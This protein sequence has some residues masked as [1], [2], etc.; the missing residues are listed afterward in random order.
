MTQQ[1]TQERVYAVTSVPSSA[2]SPVNE[3][4][5][6]AR[7]L[8]GDVMTRSVV[9]ATADAT[10]KDI[11]AAMASNRISTIPVVDD[12]HHVLGVV[13]A[14]DLLA[15]I[16]GERGRPPRGH[17]LGAGH[18]V[19]VKSHALTAA[20]LMTAPAVTT[21]E[22]M[23]I[24]TAA[25]AAALGKVRCL[26][27]VD[28]N[29]V[30]VGIATK[31]DLVKVFLRDDET[32]R[33]DILERV[34]GEGML[35]EP[36]TIDVAVGG[37]VVSLSGQLERKMLK[38]QLLERVWHVAGVVAVDSHLTYRIDDTVPPKIYPRGTY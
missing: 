10:I 27:V 31:S 34:L 12:E 32:I 8:V 37:G 11:A 3:A 30:L 16:S 21:K 19:N 35:L 1:S 6:F 26:P 5:P 38:L 33:Q 13:T 20:R 18:E 4:S 7:Q 24:E 17:R 29:G 23:P 36:G 14:S 15:R 9:S 28:D 2:A 25:A 22:Y